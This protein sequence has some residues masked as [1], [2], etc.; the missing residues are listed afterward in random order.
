M[1]VNVNHTSVEQL[2]LALGKSLKAKIKAQSKVKSFAKENGIGKT[3]LYRLFNGEGISMD[4]LIRLLRG[5][6]MHDVLETLLSEPEISPVLEWAKKEKKL[7]KK[8]NKKLKAS[9]ENNPIADL[10]ETLF[11]TQSIP[12]ARAEIN[13]LLGRNN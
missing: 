1:K 8:L 6:G 13:K 3:S 12:S 7:N 10:K 2:Q 9:L 4:N 5:L 11:E